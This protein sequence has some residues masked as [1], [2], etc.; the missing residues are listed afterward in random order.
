MITVS[1]LAPYL[2]S[3]LAVGAI[4]VVVSRRRDM[5]YRWCAWAIEVPLVTAAFWLDPPGAAAIA[6]SPQR[7]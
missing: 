3:A 2:S 1:T 6:H 5:I 4:A 7:A